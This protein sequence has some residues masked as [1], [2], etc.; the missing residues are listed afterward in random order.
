MRSKAWRACGLSNGGCRGLMMETPRVPQRVTFFSPRP[1]MGFALMSTSR[2]GLLPKV[3]LTRAPPVERRERVA[4]DVPFDAVDLGDLAAGECARRILARR[5]P[6]EFPVDD[7]CSGDPF[8]LHE[9]EGSGADR[10]AHRLRR[11]GL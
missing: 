9:D 3:E 8:L 1:F 11:I 6:V 5:V 4:H 7:L 10:L 2:A